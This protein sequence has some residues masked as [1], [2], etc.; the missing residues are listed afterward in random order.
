MATVLRVGRLVD[1]SGAP[2]STDAE[3]RLEAGRI[4]ALGARGSVTQPGDVVVER[5][6]ATATP[7]FIDVHT[8]FCYPLDGEFQTN[9]T[10]PNRLAM[11]ASGFRQ[12]ASWLSQGVTAARDVGTAF[13]LDIQLKELIAAGRRPGPRLAASGRMMTMSGGKRT[14]WDHMK[15]EVS[16][17]TE[18]RA[19]TRRHL[20]NGPDVIK[21]YCTTLLEE[22]VADY[23]R[24]ALATPE[25]APD[26]G[27]WASLSVDEI[28]AVT[29]EAH[30]LGRT[31]AAHTAPAFGIALA[32]RGGV[33]TVEHGSD[34]DDACIDLFLETGA[35]LVPTLSVSH[36]QIAGEDGARM[37][38]VFK[39]FAERRWDRIQQ[40][41]ARAHA[42][43]VKIAT[44]T[45]PVLVGMEFRTEIELLVGCGLTPAAALQAATRD[46]AACMGA[47]GRDLGTLEAGKRA[48]LLLFAGD[49]SEDVRHVRDLLEVWQDGRLVVDRVTTEAVHA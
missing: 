23:L 8:H 6:H 36:H 9:A 19:W 47:F 24:R 16:G 29:H 28:R 45:D 44:G 25:G 20:K 38:P 2:A 13:D 42:A 3:L 46:A 41:V 12:A 7:G 48:D 39:A 10:R 11:L 31:V 18:A 30:K 33:D 49:P 17:A 32:L 4:V 35:T 26:P 21:L 27:R 5:P 43:G 14:P 1:G 15:D 22:N 34:L 37:D 40:G